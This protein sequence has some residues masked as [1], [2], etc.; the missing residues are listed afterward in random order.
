MKNPITRKRKTK[1]QTKTRK[2]SPYKIT[3]IRLMKAIKESGGIK[4]KI[5]ERLG[6]TY[7]TL[8]ITLKREGANWDECRI[9]LR[10]ESERIGDLAEE[11]IHDTM[12]QRLEMSTASRTAQWY[13][14]RRHTDRGYGKK[15]QLTLEGGENPLQLQHQ[16]I[17]PID[18]L[19]L[20]LKTKKEILIAMEKLETKKAKEKDNENRK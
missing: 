12:K 14:D 10:L 20:P 4:R 2:R 11:T 13:L 19:D 18:E 3:A 7:N 5:A 17:I 8:L 9:A 1:E 16:T 6:C 15:D